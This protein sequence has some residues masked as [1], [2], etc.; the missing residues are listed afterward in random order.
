[1]AS[2]SSVAQV[3]PSGAPPVRS[4]REVLLP[5]SGLLLGMFVSILAGTVVSTS[6]PRIVADLG[7]S[8][9]SYTWVV[10]ATL[11]AT[12]VTTPIWGK[13]ADLTN[14]KLLIQLALTIFVL[15]TALAGFSQTTG[16]LIAFRGVQ[17]LG[18]GGLAALSQIIMADIISP[19]ER[20]KYM[21]LFGGVMAV[22][23]VGGP[24]AGGFITDQ[25]NW[26]GNFYVALPFAVLAVIV[27]QKT[28]HLDK[29]TKR[30][31]N[32]DYLGIVLLAG[33]V[34]L[35]LVWVTLAGGSFAWISLT[36][37]WMLGL[38]VAMLVALVFVERR[39][40]EPLIPLS[41]FS[42]RTF[43]LAVIASIS[44]GVAMFGTSVFL[45][46]YMQLARGAT[47]TMSGLMTLPMVG[48]MMISSTAFG[49]VISR[50]GVWKPIMVVGSVLV[51][52]GLAMMGTIRY[53]TPFLVVSIYMFALGTG[54]GMVMQNLVLVVQND[55]DPHQIGVASAGVTFF[56]SLGGTV[57]VSAMG[58]VLASQVTMRMADSA[59]ELGAAVKVSGEAGA[60]AAAELAQ[61]TMPSMNTLPEPMARVIEGVYGLSVAH[62]F[63]IAAPL[64][65]LTI[66]AVAL[67]PNVPLSTQTTGERVRGE[68]AAAPAPSG[69]EQ[70]EESW[71]EVA[72]AM[73]AVGADADADRHEHPEPESA[74]REGSAR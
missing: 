52:A 25:V 64:G 27:L 3:P 73:V 17:G 61:G 66:L 50:T 36:T 44:V 34:T 26:R 72:E 18:A 42:S 13:L 41:M 11:L 38:A 70:V 53:D 8:E 74:V 9:T 28:L 57:G 63:L 56:R 43:T 4:G 29:P 1:M 35:L 69:L 51:T 20:G 2:A 14:R 62:V 55:A 47:P 5:L 48:A 30:A 68:R 22:A 16:M 33:G 60:A 59:R 21:G 58:A 54:V 23:T 7:G 19:R 10:T 49:A 32:I 31:A 6:L 24:L 46:Q 15:G 12:T 37:A 71:V 67:L 39:A 40:A 65:L 45:S